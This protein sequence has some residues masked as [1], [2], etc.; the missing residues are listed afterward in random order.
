MTNTPFNPFIRI[1]CPSDFD[2]HEH[3][4][5]YFYSHQSQRDI[6]ILKNYVSCC[7]PNPPKGTIEHAN[8]CIY[9]LGYFPIL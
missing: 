6:K 7:L 8:E 9:F 4:R 1:V 2:P 5:Y 3:H